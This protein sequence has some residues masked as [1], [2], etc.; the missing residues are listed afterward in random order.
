MSRFLQAFRVFLQAFLRA[1][2]AFLHAFRSLRTRNYRLYWFGQLVSLTGSWMQDTVL[3]WLVL[4]LSGK[5]VA[6]GLTMAIRFA[7]ALLFSLHGGV[8][9]DRLRKRQTMIYCEAGQLVV[10]L[11]LATLTTTGHITVAVIFV[12][13][14]V[15]GVVEAVEG[16]IRQVFIPEMVGDE[17]L[18]NAIALGSTQFNAARIV[19]PAIGAAVLAA[20][21]RAGHTSATG[22][23]TVFYVNAA[24]FLAVII[25]LL[26]MRVS[27]LHLVPRRT[28]E[29][30]WDQLKEGLRYAASQPDVVLVLIVMG[31]LGAFG[32]N[33]MTLNPLLTKFVL[34]AGTGTLGLL[35]TSMGVGALLGGFLVAYRSRPTQRLLMVAATVFTLMLGITSVSRWTWVT[36]GLMFVM[37]WTGTLFMTTANTRLQLSVPGHMRG[38]VM[39][40][41]ALLFVGTTPIGAYVMGQL[42]DA[43]G[44]SLMVLTMAA[45]CAAGLVWG[46]LYIRGMAGRSDQ[47]AAVPPG[48]GSGEDDEHAGV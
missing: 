37:G 31:T 47:A 17:D 22:Y 3:G 44:V 39:G 16:P 38:R 24:S 23:A 19:G 18:L 29:R 34:H 10:A 6:L 12:L 42:A 7:P 33:F 28:H 30:V 36:I 35:T 20:F 15:R 13:A 26:A 25:G 2:H 14:A 32:Y 45:L 48:S 46:A 40:I 27:E 5:P 4:T 43:I 21:T 8:F 1:Y 9:A 41:Y 11:A